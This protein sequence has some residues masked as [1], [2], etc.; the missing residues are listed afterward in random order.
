VIKTRNTRILTLLTAAACACALAPATASAANSLNVARAV[1]DSARSVV[2]V[3]L[4]ADPPCADP[5]CRWYV[6]VRVAPTGTSCGAQGATV[7]RGGLDV[8]GGGQRAASFR[9][10]TNTGPRQETICLLLWDT[11]SGVQTVVFFLDWPVPGPGGTFPASPP[12]PAPSSST[13]VPASDVAGIAERS[14][15]TLTDFRARLSFRRALARRYGTAWTG[16]NRK[17]VRC[18]ASRTPGTRLCRAAF[19][20]RRVAARVFVIDGGEV[21]VNFVRRTR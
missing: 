19:R 5:N 2:D 11:V 9:Y 1:S 7:F 17:G 8:G 12:P 20:G 4:T 14:V 3:N 13:Q 6:E 21:K 15:P 10:A 16:T 18:V